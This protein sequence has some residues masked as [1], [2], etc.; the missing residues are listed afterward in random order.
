M[1]NDHGIDAASLSLA[2]GELRLPAIRAL[3]PRFAEQ[4]DKEGWPAAR[5]LAALVEH[6]L[7]ERAA[8][9][10]DRHIAQARLLPGKTPGTFNFNAVP[11]LSMP[12]VNA[13]ASS[14]SWLLD[15]SNILIFGP[16]GVGKSH[17]ASAIGLSLIRNGFRV[18]FCRTTDLVQKLQ[19]ARSEPSLENAIAKLDKF[20]LIILDDITYVS[21]DHSE[22]SALFELICSRYERRSIL[23]TANRPFDAWNSIFH[24]EAMTL[25]AVD[26]LVHHSIILEMNAD[27]YRR[28]TAEKNISLSRTST[29]PAANQNHN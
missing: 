3:W 15:G 17:L 8:R 19:Q 16:P 10:I 29:P 18:L 9:R 6:E 5:L 4:A 1:N 21:K 20:H 28:K 27:S 7:H 25:A 11:N 13:I 14:S 12:R 22:T 24:D 23:V 26:R 2:L